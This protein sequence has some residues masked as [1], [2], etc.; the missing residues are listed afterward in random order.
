MSKT[1]EQSDLSKNLRKM[2][3]SVPP[4]TESTTA[5]SDGKE[6]NESSDIQSNLRKMF[7]YVP[8]RTESTTADL[9][10]KEKKESSDIQSNL[11]K[12]FVSVPPRT[13]STTAD[14]DGKGKKESSDIQSNLRNMFVSVPSGIKKVS[15]SLSDKTFEKENTSPS[16][17]KDK[18]KDTLHVYTLDRKETYTW[19]IACSYSISH[20]KHALV[21]KC[22]THWYCSQQ[23][24]DYIKDMK[25]DKHTSIAN[26]LTSDSLLSFFTLIKRFYNLETLQMVKEYI[27]S[28]ADV[29]RSDMKKM[30]ENGDWK[31]ALIIGL[32]YEFRFVCDWE[33][34]QLALRPPFE[35]SRP[36]SDRKAIKY[37]K[38]A[39]EKGSVEAFAAIGRAL[40]MNPNHKREV[41]DN[42][43]LSSVCFKTSHIFLNRICFL[44]LDTFRISGDCYVG[45]SGLILFKL[46]SL[47]P[48][49]SRIVREALEFPLLA[50]YLLQLKSC[51]KHFRMLLLNSEQLQRTPGWVLLGRVENSVFKQE[52]GKPGISLGLRMD[53]VA[54]S[55]DAYFERLSMN[56]P[57]Y[58]CEHN[59]ISL[60]NACTECN[61]LAKQRIF[62]V[63]RKDYM[64]SRDETLVYELYGVIYSLESGLK[65]QDNFRNYSK[66]EVIFTIRFLALEPMDLHPLQ[67][68]KD[69]NIYWPIVHYYGSV[70]S[71][72]LEIL[73][74]QT[75][76]LIYKARIYY[77]S[78]IS[79]GTG[80]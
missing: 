27:G 28:Q 32:T 10:G 75:V 9:D 6:K 3:G 38:I 43:M 72:L 44:D 49:K 8:P 67:L 4:R 61:Y 26:T 51:S 54:T 42:L 41:K 31:A 59:K 37:Y 19:C 17:C 71:A 24:K 2:F 20:T 40:Y 22:G 7:V 12:M 36:F 50:K 45:T 5:D 53:V 23:C 11:R 30:A 21:C 1:K 63:Y 64:M 34:C 79:S 68:A 78:L 58:L 70:Y 35:K 52:P 69:P 74:K 33:K 15:P 73:G 80:G 57:E 56:Q 62:S 77:V 66:H 76:D 29:S 47:D 25:C 16:H 39:A 13:E 48:S 18:S 14:S 65:R 46:K 55:D 60:G